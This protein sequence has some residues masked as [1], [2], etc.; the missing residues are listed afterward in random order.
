[1]KVI[2]PASKTNGI[3]SLPG[4]PAAWMVDVKK[5]HVV[6]EEV[7]CPVAWLVPAMEAYNGLKRPMSSICMM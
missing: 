7:Y 1:M 4:T 3:V 6:T 5:E 2:G